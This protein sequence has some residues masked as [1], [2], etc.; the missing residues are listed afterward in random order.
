MPKNFVMVIRSIWCV[1]LWMRWSQDPSEAV[2]E[3]QQWQDAS[4]AVKEPLA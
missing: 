1:C 2:A 4:V 3:G